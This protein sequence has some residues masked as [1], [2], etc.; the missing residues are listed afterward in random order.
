MGECIFIISKE[1]ERTL[2]R[3]AN[4]SI[5]FLIKLGE[6]EFYKSERGGEVCLYQGLVHCKTK[7]T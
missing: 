3:E 5:K 4:N 7:E 6:M 2:I 1:I